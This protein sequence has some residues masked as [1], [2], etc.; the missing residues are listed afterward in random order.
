MVSE[1]ANYFSTLRTTDRIN[2]SVCLCSLFETKP[3]TWKTTELM[4]VNFD[5]Q[6]VSILNKYE[7][8]YL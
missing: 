5:A 2:I 7:I 4:S 1:I 3:R 6:H 8:R